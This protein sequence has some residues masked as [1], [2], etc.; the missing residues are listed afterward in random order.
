[1]ISCLDLY[2]I[3]NNIILPELNYHM[4]NTS[5]D[6]AKQAGMLGPAA[7]MTCNH[8]ILTACIS[9]ADPM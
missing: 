7:N 8:L 6:Q 3:G 2:W 9:N 1:M 5:Q 4:C